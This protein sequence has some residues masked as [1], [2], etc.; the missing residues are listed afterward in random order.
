[1][2]VLRLLRESG[3]LEGL[4]AILE[5]V[6]L[7][8]QAAA[9]SD[10]LKEGLAHEHTASRSLR[11][12]FGRDE[13]AVS[14][15]EEFLGVKASVSGF[16]QVAPNLPVAVVAVED[17][18][19][20]GEHMSHAKLDAGIKADDEYVEVASIQRR[21]AL[22]YAANKYRSTEPRVL[23]QSSPRGTQ[24]MG[25]PRE[26]NEHP[27]FQRTVPPRFR[28]ERDSDTSLGLDGLLR[29]RPRSIPQAQLS[30]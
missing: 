10:E 15:V 25:K 3:R 21:K 6:L 17:R 26:A 1:V 18:A 29:H 2:E 24:L 23:R 5:I 7:D 16:E 14:E 13:N 19:Y 11:R 22:S 9:Q 8:H 4:A 12:Q 30:A 28:Y 20:V 27:F